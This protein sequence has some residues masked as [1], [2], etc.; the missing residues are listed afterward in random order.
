MLAIFFWQ[1]PPLKYM[2]DRIMTDDR[3]CN[4]AQKE[5]AAIKQ[6]DRACCWWTKKSI[7][8]S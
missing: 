5:T 6:H 8:E 1:A 2:D 4:T 7:Q 3:G